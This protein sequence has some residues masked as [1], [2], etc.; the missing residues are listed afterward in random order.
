VGPT[1]VE[2][3]TD[4][5]AG[6]RE[7][8]G[9]A[10]P[11][12]CDPAASG[13]T[14]GAESPISARIVAAGEQAGG[15]ESGWGGVWDWRGPSAGA[16]LLTSNSELGQA[17]GQIQTG[18]SSVDFAT[19]RAVMVWYESNGTCGLSFEDL[20]VYVE[21]HSGDI[22]VVLSVTDSS[23][24]CAITCDAIGGVF[25]IVEVPL[26]GDVSYCVEVDGGQ[27]DSGG[28]GTGGSGNQSGHSGGSHSGHTG[29]EDTSNEA[30]T[31]WWN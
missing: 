16:Q 11:R 14:G 2:P 22:R 17:A 10:L 28:W 29:D 8:A 30:D 13:D 25:R 5:T 9:V 1:G 19:H 23:F 31:A 18:Y 7:L 15:G 6:S 3:D 21:E 27:C 4:D 26:T 12:S 20:D 24:G